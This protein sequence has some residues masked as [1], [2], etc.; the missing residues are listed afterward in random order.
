MRTWR[1]VRTPSNVLKGILPDICT[2]TL[3]SFQFS[4]FPLLGGSLL[5]SRCLRNPLTLDTRPLD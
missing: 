2:Y 5:L 4:I 1:H 3:F